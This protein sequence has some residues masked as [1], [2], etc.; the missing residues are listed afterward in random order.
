MLGCRSNYRGLA[1]A[2]LI[3]AAGCATTGG[4]ESEEQARARIVVTVRNDNV[5]RAT[6]YTTPEFGGRR[7]G[8][9]AAKSEATFRLDW[10]LPRIQFLAEFPDG[11]QVGWQPYLIRLGENWRFRLVIWPGSAE[12]H[13]GPGAAFAASHS[14]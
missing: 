9:V 7:L 14:R 11:E 1:L 12:S 5:K 13:A 10:D 8:V 2:V 6:V 4:G 3:A